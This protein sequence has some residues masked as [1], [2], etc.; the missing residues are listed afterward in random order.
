MKKP[1]FFINSATFKKS[2]GEINLFT[3]PI[4]NKIQVTNCALGKYIL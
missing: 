1:V 3:S 4:F 2:K